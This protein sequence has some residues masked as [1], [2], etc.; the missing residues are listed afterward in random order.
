MDL[1]E[2]LPVPPSMRKV[3][4]VE[5]TY[6]IERRSDHLWHQHTALFEEETGELRFDFCSLAIR[7]GGLP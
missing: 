7:Q 6:C 1:P 2:C 5:V 3:A 4:L